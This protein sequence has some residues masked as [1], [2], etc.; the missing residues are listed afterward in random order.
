VLTSCGFSSKFLYSYSLKDVED[1]GYTHNK[2]HLAYVSISPWRPMHKL[3]KAAL[4]Q[5]KTGKF[6]ASE[7]E[8]EP[9][10][11]VTPGPCYTKEK[12]PLFGLGWGEEPEW[13]KRK[14]HV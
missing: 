6:L 4:A 13:V 5:I 1:D 12:E 10:G 14:E 8:N 3:Y 9:V 2:T 7:E 11:I